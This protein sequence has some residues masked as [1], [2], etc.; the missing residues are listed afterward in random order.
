MRFEHNNIDNNSI[1]NRYCIETFVVMQ[2]V[3]L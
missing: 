3:C 2:I 1:R